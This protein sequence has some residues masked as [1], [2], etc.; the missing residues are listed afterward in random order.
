VR[1]D[2]TQP[3][4]SLTSTFTYDEMGRVSEDVHC[5]DGACYGMGYGYD[6]AGRLGRLT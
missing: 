4:A 5:I 1:V 2:D 6:L 3:N